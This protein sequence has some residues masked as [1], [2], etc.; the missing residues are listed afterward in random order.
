[1]SFKIIKEQEQ[2]KLYCDYVQK[3][4]DIARQFNARYEM[5]DQDL[6][7]QALYDNNGLKTS[8]RIKSLSRIKKQEDGAEALLISK[9]VIFTDKL[10]GIPKDRYSTIEGL[11]ELPL[12]TT[13]EDGVTESNQV[14]LIYDIP[15]TKAKVQEA[16]RKAGTRIVKLRFFE[17][18]ETGNRIPR[19]TPVVGNV[20]FFVNATWEELLL[21]KEK[22]IVSSR[23]N[24]LSEV[25]K[26]VVQTDADTN[27]AEEQINIEEG[28]EIPVKTEETSTVPKQVIGTGEQQPTKPGIVKLKVSNTTT[29]K[30]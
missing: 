25:R 20:D 13:N 16:L 19:D 15:F 28:N 26:D 27:K 29:K 4:I 30:D 5:S 23:L 12:I 8:D 10:T 1:M 14:R 24:R 6:R 22:K 17:G 2:P 21:G 11:I 9:D 3:K 18:P 7:I